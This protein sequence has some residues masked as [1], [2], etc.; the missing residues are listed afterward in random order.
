MIPVAIILIIL[1]IL[2]AIV[3]PNPKIDW[4]NYITAGMLMSLII[5][6]ALK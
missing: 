3:W 5:V 2:S 6:Y 1:D 4:M